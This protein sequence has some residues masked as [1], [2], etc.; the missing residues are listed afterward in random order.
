LSFPF[1][2]VLF[3]WYLASGLQSDSAAQAPEKLDKEAAFMGFAVLT[4][5]V[6][7][8]LFV[9]NMPVLDGFMRPYYIELDR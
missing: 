7:I 5:A 6:V 2:A 9:V 1:F 8:I 3:T 4:F